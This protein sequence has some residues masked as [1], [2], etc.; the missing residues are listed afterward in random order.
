[1]FKRIMTLAAISVALLLFSA[2]GAAFIGAVM[3]PS[4]TSLTTVSG[5][6]NFSGLRVGGIFDVSYEIAD[7]SSFDIILP[8]NWLPYLDYSISSGILD[9]ALSGGI[10]GNVSGL[11]VRIR[12][13][14]LD[15]VRISGSANT[16][17]WDI[18]EVQHFIVEASGASNFEA[19]VYAQS[20]DITASG[21]S[22]ISLTGIFGGGV[23]VSASGA[24]EILIGD[25]QADFVVVEASGSSAVTLQGSA[26]NVD[27]GAGGASRIDAQNLEAITATA[28]SSGSSNISVWVSESLS[29]RASGASSVRYRGNPTTIDRSTSGSGSIGAEQY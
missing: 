5:E 3:L 20:A 11:E 2:C 13:P 16:L 15:N 19:R 29:A 12:A 21:S 28:D 6:G 1:M 26:A 4:P 25:L 17:S 27:L 24:S 8:E 18:I 7:Y 9:I 14:Y 10:S 22:D 23:E